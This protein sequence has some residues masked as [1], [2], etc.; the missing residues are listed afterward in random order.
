VLSKYRSL[1]LGSRNRKIS[2]PKF[3]RDGNFYETGQ[4]RSIRKRT[5]GHS[6]PLSQHMNDRH[7][8]RTR[9]YNKK[10]STEVKE[11]ARNMMQKGQFQ[12]TLSLLNQYEESFKADV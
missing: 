9:R 3:E 4:N 11:M 6:I 2:Q 5:S 7:L 10:D 1:E 8:M 12:T